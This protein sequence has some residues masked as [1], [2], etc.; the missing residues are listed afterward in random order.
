M[1]NQPGHVCSFQFG[2]ITETERYLRLWDQISFCFSCHEHDGPASKG[3]LL[4][5]SGCVDGPWIK[6]EYK[7]SKRI[8]SSMEMMGIFVCGHICMYLG[9]SNYQL[10]R[11]VIA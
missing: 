10:T 4:A 1:V 11:A 6:Y 7:V 8:P 5:S 9:G 2:F 3:Q